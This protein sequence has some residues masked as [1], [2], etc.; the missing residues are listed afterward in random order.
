VISERA[1]SAILAERQGL[2]REQ[3]RQLL[4]AGAA[5]QAVRVGSAHAYEA[6]LVLDLA[7]RPPAALGVL[8]QECPHGVYIARLRRGRRFRCDWPWAEQ[9]E[10]LAV[11]PPM[12]PL[13]RAL[14]V[15][16][17]LV[18]QGA[19]PWIATLSGFVVLAAVATGA[20]LTEE[21]HLRFDLEPAGVWREAV[22]G[23]WFH[24]GPGRHWFAWHP[25]RLAPRPPGTP[26]AWHPDDL[27]PPADT[28][29][30][31]PPLPPAS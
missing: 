27:A 18:S 7:Q 13:T 26:T 30:A 17:P 11:Q 23:R 25:D 1:A 2:G 14:V 16:V 24:T 10:V 6:D 31:W 29:S 21:G 15:H 22:E 4:L 9:A 8:A 19:L 28:M 3:A 12:T 20:R 5:G